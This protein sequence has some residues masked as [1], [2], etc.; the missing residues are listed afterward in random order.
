MKISADEVLGGVLVVAMTGEG[1]WMHM[2]IG[3]LPT[4]R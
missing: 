2:Y 4:I 3:V 1:I